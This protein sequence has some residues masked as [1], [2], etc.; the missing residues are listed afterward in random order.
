MPCYG[1]DQAMVTGEA[2]SHPWQ[3]STLNQLELE[4][5]AKNDGP[6]ERQTFTFAKV[7]KDSRVGD[8]GVMLDIQ[9]V[10]VALRV[11]FEPTTEHRHAGRHSERWG[12]LRFLAQRGMLLTAAGTR[13]KTAIMRKSVCNSPFV[14]SI[15]LAY[16]M[17]LRAVL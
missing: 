2:T 5:S 15:D 7:F 11:R 9:Q 6:F 8:A 4:S 10:G 1:T 14:S 3:G 13:Q 12:R 16:S 17:L